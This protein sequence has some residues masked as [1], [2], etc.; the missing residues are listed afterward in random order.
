MPDMPDEPV[1]DTPNPDPQ[2][3]PDETP[4]GERSTPTP[5]ELGDENA[6]PV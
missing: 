2:L 6:Q 1:G 3:A 4:E 5:H